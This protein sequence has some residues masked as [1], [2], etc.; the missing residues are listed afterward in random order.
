ML[1]IIAITLNYY[2]NERETVYITVVPRRLRHRVPAAY[3]YNSV[4]NL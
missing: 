2:S 1:Y 4:F 3:L